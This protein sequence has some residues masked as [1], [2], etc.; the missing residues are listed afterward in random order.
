MSYPKRFERTKKIL[1]RETIKGIRI[2]PL[3]EFPSLHYYWLRSMNYELRKG[4]II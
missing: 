2:P 1:N 3:A 4:L